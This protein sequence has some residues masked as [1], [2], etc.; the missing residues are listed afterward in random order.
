MNTISSFKFQAILN[1]TSNMYACLT[2]YLFLIINILYLE[3]QDNPFISH[4]SGS[5]I[6][7][8]IKFNRYKK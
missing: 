3:Q 1:I 8:S 7:K 4:L 2:I 6:T 5:F